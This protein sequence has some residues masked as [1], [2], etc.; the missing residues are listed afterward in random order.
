VDIEQW[1][2]PGTRLRLCGCSEVLFCRKHLLFSLQPRIEVERFQ[3]CQD[4]AKHQRG[5][6]KSLFCVDTY[7]KCAG[8]SEDDDMVVMMM[9]MIM[10]MIMMIMI[11][12]MML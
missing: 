2:K 9:M 4:T 5:I 10:I 6:Q 7:D 1:Q 12:T 8:Y 11:T 3:R